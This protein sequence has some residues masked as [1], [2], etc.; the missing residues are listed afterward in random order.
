MFLLEY[1]YIYIHRHTD[2][3]PR[4]VLYSWQSY[5]QDTSRSICLCHHIMSVAIF[6]SSQTHFVPSPVFFP[7]R[8]FRFFPFRPMFYPIKSGKNTCKLR[9]SSLGPPFSSRL[10]EAVTVTCVAGTG[11]AWKHPPKGRLRLMGTWFLAPWEGYT[12]KD[13]PWI[14]QG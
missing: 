14:S 5:R 9:A 11:N 2:L 1:I 12:R 10:G 3:S 8:F 13:V 4:K 7:S 6:R